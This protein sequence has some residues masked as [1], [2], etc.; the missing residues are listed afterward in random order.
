MALQLAVTQVVA[1]V[2]YEIVVLPLTWWFVHRVKQVE[3][4][5]TIDDGVN[6]NPFKIKDI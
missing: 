6:Y 5:D 3:G 2:L 4:I 1:K